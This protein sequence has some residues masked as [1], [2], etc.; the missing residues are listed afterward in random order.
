MQDAL[1]FDDV[2]LVPQYSEIRP[3]NVTTQTKFSRNIPLRIP[4]VSSPM[5]TVTEHKMAVAMALAGGIGIIHKNLSITEQAEEVQLVKRF[6]NGF[7]VDSITVNPDDNVSKVYKIRSEKGYKKVPVVNKRGQLVG[8]ITNLDYFWPNDKR[9][10]VRQVMIRSKDLITAQASTSLDRANDIIRKKKLSILCLV[11]KNGKLSSIVTRKDL[12]KN[13]MYPNA[14][15]DEHKSLRVGAAVGAG[16]DALARARA[17]VSAGVDVVVIDTAHGHS[18]GVIEA[19][20]EFK[21][22]KIIKSVDV[23]AGNVGT[24]EAVED[25]IKAGAD[26]VK[27]GIGPGSICTTRVVAGI[28]VPQISAVM[29]AIKGRGKHKDVP[30]NA[31]GGIKYSGDIAKALAVGADS[32]M[33]GSLLAGTEESPGETEFYNGRMYKIYRGMGSIGAMKK[34]SKD[35]YGQASIKESSKFVPEGIEGILYRGKVDNVI[36]QLE[37]GLRSGMAYVGAK[38]IS[39][40]HK[41]AKFVRITNAGLIESHPHDVEI[42]KESPNYV[43]GV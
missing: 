26:G 40:L 38:N 43:K 11:E 3:R 30:I 8:L 19:V 14:N 42:T 32:V 39:E 37:G 22:D 34:G 36:Y 17:L 12:E 15:K 2:L 4:L 31:D 5:D 29:D 25:L 23:V 7:I 21:H 18:K 13:E 10:K 1:T 9:K 41:K 6:E 24:G 27:V 20:K 33:I 35:R 16:E 28:G